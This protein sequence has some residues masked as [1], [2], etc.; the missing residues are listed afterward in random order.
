[1]TA[2]ADH[3]PSSRAYAEALA[4][5]E[6]IVGELESG[7]ADV[8]ALAGRVERAGELVRFCRSRLDAAHTD[9]ERILAQLEPDRGLAPNSVGDPEDPEDTSRTTGGAPTP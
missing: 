2:S 3:E 9:V 1:M 6:V 5:L 7:E 4:E 8:D